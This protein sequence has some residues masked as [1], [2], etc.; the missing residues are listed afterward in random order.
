MIPNRRAFPSGSETARCVAYA[1]AWAVVLGLVISAASS[2][3]AAEYS[4]LY[5]FTGGVDGKYPYARLLRDEAGNLY[6]TTRNGG[7]LGFGAAFRLEAGSGQ[8]TV[9]HSFTGADGLEPWGPL[10]KDEAGNLYGTTLY[11]GTREGGVCRHGCGT[12]FKLDPSGHFTVLHAFTGGAD[13]SQPS[14]DLL[15]DT[16]GNLYGAT[17]AGGDP[18]CYGC[19]LVFKLDQNGNETVVYNF[20][21]APKGAGPDGHLT[22]DEA[23][24][25]YGTTSGGGTYNHGTVF[26]LDPAG[27]ETTLYS[28]TGGTDG[29]QPDGGVVRDA[30]GNL[31]GVTNY[32]GDPLCSCGVVFK[33]DPA[34]ALTVLYTITGDLGVPWAGLTWDQEGNLYGATSD[35]I[36]PYCKPNCGAVFRINSIRQKSTDQVILYI[37]PGGKEGS[38]PYGGVIRDEAGNLYGAASD[39]GDS[40][41]GYQRAGCGVVFKLRP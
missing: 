11:G 30:S 33:V 34:G 24:N 20:T 13:G 28:F 26:K 29:Y 17:H 36:Y 23:G 25:F 3:S 27:H 32:G 2:A 31:Y 21:G 35:Y 12:V 41:C 9:L 5:T 37:F 19:G 16:E 39:G 38:N 14:G 22:R 40:S 4:V 8:L 15:P 18:S 10:I 7:S 6:G 1:L